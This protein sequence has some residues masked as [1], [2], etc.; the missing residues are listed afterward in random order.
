MSGTRA[1]GDCDLCT[2]KEVPIKRRYRG[3][4]YCDTCYVREFKH[5]PCPQC[6]AVARLPVDWESAVCAACE[7]RAPC[8]RCGKVDE[9]RGKTTD[10]GRLCGVCVRRE[11]PPEPCE[12]CA[13]PSNRLS[14]YAALEHDLRV[15]PQCAR[16]TTHETCDG[17]RRHRPVETAEDGRR[18]CRPC[19]EE[20]E[21]PCD[22]CRESMPAGYGRQCGGCAAKSRAR[23]RIEALAATMGAPG[24][25][26]HFTAFGEWLVKTA[27]AE[28]AARKLARYAELFTEMRETWGAI[29]DYPRLVTHFGAE[30]LRRQRT[31]MRW[32]VEQGLVTVDG[33][34]R[35]EDSERRQIARCLD[36]LPDGS[37]AKVVMEGYHAMLD[38]RVREGRL[39]RHSMRLGI[40]P[41][42]TL[43]EAAQTAGMPLPS[44]ETLE[45]VLRRAPGQR[46]ALSGFVGWLRETHGV[47]LT[48]PAKSRA[49]AVRRRRE[50]AR[51]E[52]L[53][54]M[55]EGP[56]AE[57]FAK[58]W[59]RTALVYFHDLALSAGRKV[60][61][62]DVEIDLDGLR[63]EID[64][65]SYWIPSPP[66]V[67]A[68]GTPT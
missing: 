51:E 5:R 68:E 2:R 50:I 65:K 58:R 59:R 52:M 7:R 15:C 32:M 29:P 67:E 60:E 63:V 22:T 38:G 16:R 46:A 54:L 61:D 12:L 33:A 28:A 3:L 42:V 43:L 41:A 64:G 18:L 20:G 45:G 37:R 19:R 17:C 30:G 23:R 9:R 27:G 21:H 6:G 56:G 66:E 40:A 35:E 25:T 1:T 53:T 44:Q 62:D 57:D 24:I 49:T 47:A 55:R 8:I 48:L 10:E 39:T 14:R 31:P 11:R 26:E 4:R 36:R 34:V 13:T